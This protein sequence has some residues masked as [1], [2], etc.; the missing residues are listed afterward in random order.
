MR[1][2][3]ELMKQPTGDI[4]HLQASHSQREL[5]RMAAERDRAREEARKC[6]PAIDDT[7]IVVS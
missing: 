3:D 1:G 7:N 4:H 6:V 2:W 5:E